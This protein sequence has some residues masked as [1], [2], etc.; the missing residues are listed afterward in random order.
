MEK[1][2]AGRGSICGWRETHTKDIVWQVVACLRSYICQG[3]DRKIW[4]FSKLQGWLH[5]IQTQIFPS[6]PPQK[7]LMMSVT[8]CRFD[9]DSPETQ[10]MNFRLHKIFNCLSV[11]KLRHTFT[12]DVDQTKNAPSKINCSLLMI[13][14]S[15]FLSFSIYIRGCLF[16]ACL[17]Y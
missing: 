13:Q 14:T 16:I 5:H 4:N 9:S 2:E 17:C 11:Y 6:F 8:C 3:F 15:L 12:R 7:Q 1:T 10:I